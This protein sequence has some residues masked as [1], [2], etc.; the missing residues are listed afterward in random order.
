MAGAAISGPQ[1]LAAAQPRLFTVSQLATLAALVDLIIPTT[2]AP[3]AS[4]AGVHS[5][6]DG[7]VARAKPL[8]KRWLDG[9]ECIE[10]EARRGGNEAFSQL[11]RRQQAAILD[12]VEKSNTAFF[13]LLRDSAIDAYYGTR[14]GLVSG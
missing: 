12:R 3:G 9:I 2:G 4:E 11:T 10:A 5:I 14:A 13:S 6:I 1:A 8:Q 7:I